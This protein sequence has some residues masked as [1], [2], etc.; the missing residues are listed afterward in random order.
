MADVAAIGLPVALPIAFLLLQG[1]VL[2]LWPAL[3]GTVAYVFMVIAPLLAAAAAL[4]RGRAEA[5]PA[6][7]G[8]W[9]VAGSITTWAV[10][11]F[12]NLWHELVLG[13][14]NEMYPDSMLAFNLAAVPIT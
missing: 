14:A 9:L 1:V 2:T 8:W 3:A 4:W 13:Q 12:L 5:Q 10:G 6:R 11:A 7:R